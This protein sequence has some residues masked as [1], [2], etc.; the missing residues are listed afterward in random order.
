VYQTGDRLRR[1]STHPR[2][3]RQGSLIEIPKRTALTKS[4]PTPTSAKVT[5][6]LDAVKVTVPSE[7]L[8]RRSFHLWWGTLHLLLHRRRMHTDS[9]STG[10]WRGVSDPAGDPGVVRLQLRADLLLLGGGHRNQPL[11]RG[12]VPQ[13][14]DA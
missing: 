14:L 2:S 13:H 7:R 12:K 3:R 11:A 8:L 6:L 4:A 9:V 1:G 10:E 5:S